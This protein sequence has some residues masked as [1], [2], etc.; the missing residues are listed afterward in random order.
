MKRISVMGLGRSGIA[1]AKLLKERGFE[2]F[3]SDIN[4]KEIELDDIEVELG[5]NSERILESNMIVVSPGIPLSHP[6]ILKARKMGLPVVGELEMASRFIPEGIPIVA[7]TGTNGKT[8]TAFMIQKILEKEDRSSVVTGNASPGIPLSDALTQIRDGAIPIIEVSTFQLETIKEFHPNIAVLL[9]ISPD[10]L[11]RHSKFDDYV[12]LKAKIFVNQ[13]AND[14]GILNFDDELVKRIGG[15]LSSQKI[16]F[17]IKNKSDA[18]VEDNNIVWRDELI[19]NTKELTFKGDFF[20]EDALAAVA[21]TKTLDVKTENLR[22]GLLDWNGIPHRLEFV[23]EKRG[24]KFINNSMCTNPAAFSKTLLS[25]R[26]PVILIAGGK[27][28]CID[29]TEIL[30]A[31]TKGAKST[32]LLGEVKLELKSLLVKR[33]YRRVI[34]TNSM[35]EAVRQAFTIAFPGDTILLSPGFASFDLFKDFQERGE[36]FKEAVKRL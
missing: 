35:E 4:Y 25:F 22:Q 3:A 36:K 19:C 16:F 33:G 31:I 26:K 30:D 20:L 24:V 2:V 7:I 13:G 32:I 1:C 21:V 8:M 29:Y 17:S 28:K 23:A 27:T 11:D 6:I 10:H 12:K 18:Y 9:N 15:G 5:K 34:C 14:F